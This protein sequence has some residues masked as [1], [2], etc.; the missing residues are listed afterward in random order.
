MRAVS[1]RMGTV[2][3]CFPTCHDRYPL[4]GLIR[5]RYTLLADQRELHQQRARGISDNL[6]SEI[7]DYNR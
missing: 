6:I 3:D 1:L 4:I 7:L 2:I 5:V